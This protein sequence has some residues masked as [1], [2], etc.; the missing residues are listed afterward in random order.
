MSPKG[1][2]IKGLVSGVVLW[3]MMELLGAGVLLEVFGSRYALVGLVGPCPLSRSLLLPGCEKAACPVTYSL[4]LAPYSSSE[5][6]SN[7][8]SPNL[9][10]KLHNHGLK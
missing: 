10:Q 1:S 6:Q 9:D 2:C 3:E 4:P 7:K 8:S 5:A